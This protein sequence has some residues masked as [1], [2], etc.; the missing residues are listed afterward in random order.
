MSLPDYL[1]EDEA[2]E[3]PQCGGPSDYG[4]R[5]CGQCKH[6]LVDMNADLAYERM[7]ER[8]ER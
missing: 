8:W 4:Q 7:L 3:C 1:L 2:G 5:L 6:D